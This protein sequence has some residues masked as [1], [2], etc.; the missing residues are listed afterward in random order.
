MKLTLRTKLT[1]SY[2]ALALVL[3]LSLIGAAH[4]ALQRHFDRYIMEKQDRDMADIM[5]RL[6][7]AFAEQQDPPDL[8]VLASI[9]AMAFSRGYRLSVECGGRELPLPGIGMGM[10]MR[11]HGTP[12]EGPGSSAFH[13]QADGVRQTQRFDITA[14]GQVCGAAVF[15]FSGPLFYADSDLRFLRV[16]NRLFIVGGALSLLFALALGALMA[17]RIS[18]PLKKVIQS[19][20]VIEK[21]G[22]HE[23]IGF[24]SDTLEVQTLIQSV[25]SLAATLERQ[26]NL[27]RRLAQDYAHELRTP[28]ATLKSH[29]EAMIDGIWEPTPERLVSC[30][31]EIERLTRMVK[32]VEN[33]AALEEQSQN[34]SLSRFSLK[35]LAQAQALNF[36]AEMSAKSLTLAVEGEDFEIEAD[37]DKIGQILVNLLSNALKYSF[38]GGRITVAV[39]REPGWA[40]LKVKDQGIGI[41]EKELP[42]IFEHLYRADSSRAAATGG[43]GIGLAVVKA[44]ALA[45]GGSVSAA[46][47]PGKGSEFTLRLPLKKP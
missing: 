23:R 7:D 40:L 36:E 41:D 35:G 19:T 42:F 31:E 17:A 25:N 6:N 16:L 8:R 29:L 14:G 28:L 47:A 44:A 32:G 1:A 21:G 9:R 10:G 13:P 22:Y 24:N 11:R 3:A 33:L 38:S 26:K 30:H 39:A 34:L 27:R 2:M 18:T 20:G 5:A 45:H 46:S 4:W 12:H 37:R 43:S 15:N